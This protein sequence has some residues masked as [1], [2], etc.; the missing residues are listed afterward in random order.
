MGNIKKIEYI[1]NISYWSHVSLKN[2]M[3]QIPQSCFILILILMRFSNFV[4]CGFIPLLSFV[5]KPKMSYC[6]NFSI[7]KIKHLGY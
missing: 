1:F 2:K 7:N 6:H 3:F 4:R 5:N